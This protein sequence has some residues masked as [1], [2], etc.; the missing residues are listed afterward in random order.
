MLHNPSHLEAVNPVTIGKAKAKQEDAGSVSQVLPVSVHGDAAF[1]GQGIVYETFVIGQTPYYNTAGTVHVICNNQIGFTT[2]P[3]FGRSCQYSSDICKM[4][5]VPVIHVNAD[6][7]EDV[8]R[9]AQLALE[10]RQTFG[11]DILIDLI[12]TPSKT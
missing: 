6:S 2:T 12:G 8:F 3:K 1:A 4:N 10:Y 5:G 11:K 7:V 9:V